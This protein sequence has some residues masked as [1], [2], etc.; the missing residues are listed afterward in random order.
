MKFSGQNMTVGYEDRLIINGLNID[1]PEGKF[2]VIIGPNGCGKSTL[3]KSFARLLRP[4]QGNVLLDGKSI[5]EIPTLRLA[6]QIGLLPQSPLVPGGITV[7]DLVSR[8][9]FP[10][11]NFLGQLSKADYEAISAAMEAMGIMDLADKP[12]DS[13]SGGQRQ[14]LTLLMATIKKPKVLLLDEHT[15]PNCLSVGRQTSAHSLQ[16]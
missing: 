1:I 3:L 6:R 5:Y 12:V 2:S 11:Q 4:Q 10:Y 15:F 16:M 13:L 7:A 9:R 14:A 8:G